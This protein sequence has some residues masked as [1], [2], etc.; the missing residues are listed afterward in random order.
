MSGPCQDRPGVSAET[1]GPALW[2]PGRARP[3]LTSHP[4][5]TARMLTA[6]GQSTREGRH[7]GLEPVRL[8]PPG[9]H[10][11]RAGR[12]GV[13]GSPDGPDCGRNGLAVLALWDVRDRRAA[14]QRP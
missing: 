3:R 9:A 2:Q 4:A 8:C 11:L 14:R 6:T 13:A 10:D 1:P 5:A 12:T 7:V